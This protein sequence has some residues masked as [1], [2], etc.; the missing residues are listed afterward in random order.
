MTNGNE[1]ITSAKLDIN[2]TEIDDYSYSYSALG[3]AISIALKLF[4]CQLADGSKISIGNI[5]DV[6]CA[7]VINI[8]GNTETNMPIEIDRMEQVDVSAQGAFCLKLTGNVTIKSFSSGTLSILGSSDVVDPHVLSVGN[9]SSIHIVSGYFKAIIGE[10]AIERDKLFDTGS[11]RRA[12]TITYPEGCGLS[13]VTGTND[14]GEDGYYY[15][16]K[17]KK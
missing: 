11:G 9:K 12:G 3:T 5:S 16:T 15:I 13:T 8:T 7:G 1:E 17:N 6:S 2:I 14:G 4:K 10:N